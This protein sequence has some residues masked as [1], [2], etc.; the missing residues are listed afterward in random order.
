MSYAHYWSRI[1]VPSERLP[2]EPRDAYGRLAFDTLAFIAAA[3]RRGVMLADGAA[4][5]GSRPVVDEGGIWLNGARPH[6]C[7]AFGW[8]AVPGEPWWS[9][10]PGHR[11]W[12]ACATDRRPY[13]AVVCAILIRAAAHYGPSVR[14]ASD[15]GWDGT[16]NG[17]V[18]QPEWVAARRLVIAVFGSTADVC[19]LTT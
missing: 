6:Q 5:P 15:G 7:E 1:E 2:P 12:D 11:W 19:P 14:I 8:P 13:D 9:N 17:D 16:T 3:E 10:Q 18:W 4:H